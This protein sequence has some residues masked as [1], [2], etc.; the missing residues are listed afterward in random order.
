L[1]GTGTFIATD[2][3]SSRQVSEMV[4]KVIREFGDID[5]FDWR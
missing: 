5:I 1:G 3:S 4:E 2:V